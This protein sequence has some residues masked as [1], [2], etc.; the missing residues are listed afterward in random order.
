MSEPKY[1]DQMARRKARR[2]F[3]ESC[4]HTWH[5]DDTRYRCEKCGAL[6]WKGAPK[7]GRPSTVKA[8]P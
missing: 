2:V 3:R 6:V 8:K 5:E 1:A 7:R 4:P